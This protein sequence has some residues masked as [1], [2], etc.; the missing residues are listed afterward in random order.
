MYTEVLQVNQNNIAMFRAGRS[1]AYAERSQSKYSASVEQEPFRFRS[2]CRFHPHALIHSPER[3]CE[4]HEDGVCCRTTC[5]LGAG[6]PTAYVFVLLIKQV[7]VYSRI[8][9]C[10]A[11]SSYFFMAVSVK[12]SP[13]SALKTQDLMSGEHLLHELIL[14][15]IL[16]K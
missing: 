8:Q 14:V 4:S 6:S 3:T 15:P 1:S 10:I 13:K 9:V 5:R 7:V 2:P 16:L 12:Y 11:P